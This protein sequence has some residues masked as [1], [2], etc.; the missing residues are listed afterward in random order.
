MSAP[1]ET[2]DSAKTAAVRTFHESSREVWI[3]RLTVM[4]PVWTLLT[5]WVFFSLAS[6][7]FATWINFNNILSQ[8]ATAGILAVGITFVLLTAEI[9]LSI[10]AVMG[11]AGTNTDY[12]GAVGGDVMWRSQRLCHDGDARTKFHVHTRHVID[13]RRFTPVDQSGSPVFS[14]R[15]LTP[16]RVDRQRKDWRE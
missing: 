6:S 4:A 15:S 1:S 14:E 9:D 7:S 12:R 2:P 10:A 16:H 13:R 5:M 3:R 8:V 11:L